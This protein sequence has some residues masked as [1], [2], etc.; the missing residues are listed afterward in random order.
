MGE[1]LTYKV[2]CQDYYKD[3]KLVV[4]NVLYQDD[5]G[6]IYLVPRNFVTDLYSIPNI[7]AFVVGDSAGRDTRPSIVHD[8][9]CA[10]HKLIKV[11]L[12]KEQLK[13]LGYLRAHYSQEQQAT[14]TV[15]EDIPTYYL[16]FKEV[17][18]GSIND[19]FGR[20]MDC[21]RIDKRGLIRAGVAF[22]FNFYFK[23]APYTL[24]D[25]YKIT[26]HYKR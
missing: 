2:R 20:M 16:S 10:Y 13:R 7:F 24:L 11:D 9:G 26:N 4:D 6:S 19:M 1:F 14:I 21:L 15:C 8:F 12:T 23:K 17:T 3:L 25:C 22:N 5:D 18:K